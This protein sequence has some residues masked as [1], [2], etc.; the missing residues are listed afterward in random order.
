MEL[1]MDSEVKS[2]IIESAKNNFNRGISVANYKLLY[3]DEKSYFKKYVATDD[4]EIA[5]LALYATGTHIFERYQTYPILHITG[6]YATGKNRRLDLLASICLNPINLMNSSLSYLFRKLDE[7]KGTILIDEADKFLTD[8]DMRN[9]L[10]A[11]YNKGGCIARSVQ[12]NAHPKGFRPESFEVYSPKVLVT[13]EGIETDALNSRSITIITFPMSEDSNVPY[14]LPA[15]ALVEGAELKNRIETLVSNNN[16]VDSTDIKLGLR[17]RDAEIFE[18]LKDVAFIYGEEAIEDLQNFVDHI[19]IPETKYNT[20]LSFHEDLIRVLNDC[21][22]RGE[23]AHL[24]LLQEKLLLESDDYKNTPG[25]RISR[26]LRSLKFHIDRDNRGKYV[27]RNGE[28]LNIWRKRYLTDSR[29]VQFSN[30]TPILDMDTAFENHSD[31]IGVES[32]GGVQVTRREEPQVTEL[33]E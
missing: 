25:R 24:T 20:M 29:D 23:I 21:W 9:F 4:I 6:D 19:Y 18:C 22:E 14:T 31:F 27:T 17:G 1:K 32:V 12:D 33:M 8:E 10:Q 13:R 15:D 5:I 16:T 11:G 2:Q 7:G 30:R 28:L 26:V 3:K